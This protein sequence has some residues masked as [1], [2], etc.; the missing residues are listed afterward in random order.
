LWRNHT[1][2]RSFS[3]KVWNDAYLAAFAQAANFQVAT[4]D[5]GFAQ[6][7]NVRCVILS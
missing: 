6:Y 4:F 1:Q 2:Q 3:P 7:Q 5:R